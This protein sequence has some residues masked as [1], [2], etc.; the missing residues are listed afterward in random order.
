MTEDF[1][2]APDA[3]LVPDATLLERARSGDSLAYGELWSRHY[4]AGVL[5]ARSVT[6]SLDA[7]DLVQEAFT[8]I[9]QAIQHGGGPHGAFRAYLFTCIRNTAA[10]WG[11][12]RSE[13]NVEDLDVID[14]ASSATETDAALDR[15]L[16]NTAFRSLPTRWQEVLWYTEI[17]Q[18]KPA[19]AAPL[20]GMKASAVA[21]LALRAREGLR[22]AWITA[23]LKSLDDG[24]MCQW[25]IE[26][27]AAYTR[28][29]VSSRDRAK[30]DA[31][32]SECTRCAIVAGEAKHVSSRLALVLLPLALGATG[33]TGYLATLQ[34]GG[35]SLV[36]LA[37]GTA[38][39]M[40]GTVLASGAGTVLGSGAGSASVMSVVGNAGAG[41]SG[42]GAAAGTG[43][44]VGVLSVA[45]A[46]A[47]IA[48]AAVITATVVATSSP[49]TMNEASAENTLVLGAQTMPDIVMATPDSD[50]VI[51]VLDPLPSPSPSDVPRMLV[52]APRTTPQPAPPGSSVT[53]PSPSRVPS[54][55]P[56]PTVEP[57]P[58]T[59]P[60]EDPAPL[61]SPEPEPTPPLGASPAPSVA[62]TSAPAPDP[63][64]APEPTPEPSPSVDPTPAPTPEP[65]PEP[66]L[67]PTPEPT[68]EPTPTP[69]PTPTAEPT[70]EPTVDPTPEP[71]PPVSDTPAVDSWTLYG[72]HIAHVVIAGT[73]GREVAVVIDGN[74]GTSSVISNGSASVLL[75]S[76][77]RIGEAEISFRYLDG[78]Q[79][80]TQ[81]LTGDE[82]DALLNRG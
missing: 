27:L 72:S 51:Q 81:T 64:L 47:V 59:A 61:P 7:D 66:T 63:S 16:T 53:A 55:A 30:I 74:Q 43:S 62:P 4:S 65:T 6:T 10:S 24:S 15:S 35:L 13:T 79:E 25:T 41:S 73:D 68:A 18:L 46:S 9:F 33:A 21:Q 12:A 57:A 44:F 20:L 31:H 2:T 76:W 58:S 77:R 52:P 19:Q 26:R 37:S 5:A 8:R 23:H 29:T 3:D 34:G 1:L 17:E 11:R 49:E 50:A 56:L 40:P 67:T 69:E 82:W 48:G 39:A 78:E 22:E 54:P 32:L 80:Q 36:A 75:V 42:V 70:P 38:P 60:T 45:A 28:D 14:P 71:S